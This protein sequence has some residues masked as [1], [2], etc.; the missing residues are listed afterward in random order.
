M[1]TPIEKYSK[2]KSLDV[3]DFINKRTGNAA[4]SLC[5]TGNLQLLSQDEDDNGQGYLAVKKSVVQVA[6]RNNEIESLESY[7]YILMCE[8]CGNE[9]LINAAFVDQKMSVKGD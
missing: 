5:N 3:L 7:F 6:N 8:N 2:K 4:C 9:H 1:T